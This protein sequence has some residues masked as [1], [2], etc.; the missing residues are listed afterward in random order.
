MPLTEN[1]KLWITKQLAIN[2]AESSADIQEIKAQ[3]HTDVEAMETKLLTAFHRWAS[4]LEARFRTHSAALRAID[5]EIEYISDRVKALEA[6][7]AA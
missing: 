5:E 7:S 6:K 2:R 4:P 3:V 1:D